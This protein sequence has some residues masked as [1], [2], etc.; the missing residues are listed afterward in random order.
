MKVLYC[1]TIY[2][3][4]VIQLIPHGNIIFINITKTQIYDEKSKN[5][6]YNLLV[7]AEIM[8]KV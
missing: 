5:W 4:L 1:Y 7:L 3:T 8:G 2:Q 6:T